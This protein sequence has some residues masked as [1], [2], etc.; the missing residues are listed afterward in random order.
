MIA[1]VLFAGEV[2][3]ADRDF[4]RSLDA[5]IL[6][7]WAAQPAVLARIPVENVEQVRN[8]PRVHRF[9]ESGTGEFPGC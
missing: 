2:T 9:I 7:E 1:T 6:Y 8:H 3:D 5:E 4:L